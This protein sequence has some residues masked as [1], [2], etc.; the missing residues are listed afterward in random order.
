MHDLRRWHL[1]SRHINEFVV[2]EDQFGAW[3]TL[4][5]RP[6]EDFGIIV[7]AEPD[8]SGDLIPV[9]TSQLMFSWNRDDEA[10]LFIESAMLSGL[11][12]TTEIDMRNGGR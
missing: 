11:P 8:E 9:R 6:A 4:R 7:T 1:T 5:S 2:A 12:D 10:R 3:N